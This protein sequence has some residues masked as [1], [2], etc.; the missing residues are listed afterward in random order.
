MKPL[1]KT[2]TK[3]L[4]FIVL[5]LA[6]QILYGQATEFLEINLQGGERAYVGTLMEDTKHSLNIS[7]QM[8]HVVRDLSEALVRMIKD[9]KWANTHQL[10]HLQFTIS[11]WDGLKGEFSGQ[12]KLMGIE[13]E[14]LAQTQPP[15]VYEIWQGHYT[16]E[17]RLLGFSIREME[18]R[19][20]P[21][22]FQDVRITAFDLNGRIKNMI[23]VNQHVA[24]KLNEFE[25][26]KFTEGIEI[27]YSQFHDNGQPMNLVIERFGLDGKGQRRKLSER[28]LT[29]RSFDEKGRLRTETVKESSYQYSG[30]NQNVAVLYNVVFHPH[31]YLEKYIVGYPL[32]DETTQKDIKQFKEV[33][34]L[35]VD[36]ALVADKLTRYFYTLNSQC[37]Y[38]HGNMITLTLSGDLKCDVKESEFKIKEGF[39]GEDEEGRIYEVTRLGYEEKNGDGHKIYNRQLE[40]RHKEIVLNGKSRR[41]KFL[42]SYRETSRWFSHEKKI[43]EKIEAAYFGLVAHGKIEKIRDIQIWVT[44]WV[45]NKIPA[46]MNLSIKDHDSEPPFVQKIEHDCLYVMDEALFGNLFE[47]PSP[48]TNTVEIVY[49]PEDLNLKGISMAEIQ[50]DLSAE[51][52]G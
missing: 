48:L 1:G 3:W 36:G 10:N 31:G 26:L 21:L 42:K 15:L 34:N 16:N 41:G 13:D 22:I 2:V 45:E 52:N 4:Q 19:A 5:I 47:V 50:P 49:I 44:S 51:A 23:I 29:G 39:T 40:V 18:T 20:E 46:A 25:L 12:L 6:P 8:I 27:A 38:T 17:L 7:P 37:I 43:P 11:R 14:N 9:L 24:V 33:W 32:G 35:A 30:I 28:H